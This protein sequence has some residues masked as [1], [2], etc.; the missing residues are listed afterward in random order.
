MIKP[1]CTTRKAV[2]L[3]ILELFFAFG[4]VGM[5][6]VLLVFGNLPKVK[7]EKRLD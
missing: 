5:P 1:S 2:N 6:C 7:K 4:K 3:D